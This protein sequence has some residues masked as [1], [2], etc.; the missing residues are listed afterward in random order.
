MANAESEYV[1]WF[2][3]DVVMKGAISYLLNII[4]K[5]NPILYSLIL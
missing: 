2:G 4:E 1:W 5:N 3:D